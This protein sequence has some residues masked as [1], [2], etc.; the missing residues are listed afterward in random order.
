MPQDKA[1]IMDL[2]VNNEKVMLKIYEAL[3]PHRAGDGVLG[4]KIPQTS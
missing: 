3:F 2:L 4:K 1:N